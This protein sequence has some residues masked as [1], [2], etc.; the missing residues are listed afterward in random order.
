MVLYGTLNSY[1][2]FKIAGYMANNIVIGLLG[3]T[4]DRGQS[5]ER[6]QRWRPSVA[7]SQHDDFL[8]DRFEL[9]YQKEHQALA[10][11][12][13][14]DI[15]TVSPDIE[16][17]LHP[18]EIDDPWD[19]QSVYTTLL[20]FSRAYP[21]QVDDEDYFIHVTTG[22]QV[23]QI[24]LFLLNE[25]R[26]LPGRLIQES[27]PE[28]GHPGQPGEY[29]T[30]DLDLSKY[31]TIASRFQHEQAASMSALK[32]GIETGNAA[33]N[34]L[35]EQIERVAVWSPSPVLM[36]GPP[37]AGKSRLAERIYQQKRANR[38]V[39]GPFVEVNCATLR[40]GLAM[41]TLFGHVKGAFT[42]AVEDR[43][44]LLNAAQGGVL[45]LDEI[46]EL[47]LDE[48]TM[49]LRAL[50]AN[51]YL[52]VGADVEVAGDFQLI[53]STNRDLNTDVRTGRFRSD[54]LA[55]INLWT[56]YL[57]GLSKRP[58]DIEPNIEFELER[59]AGL[60]GHRVTFNKEAKA[61]FLQFALRPETR[62]PGNFRDLN[63]AITRMATLATG[64]RI[65]IGT[66]DEE[67]GRLEDDW[68]AQ[69]SADRP[70]D[71]D[72]D[73]LERVLGDKRAATI[74]LFDRA[75]LATVIRVCRD[76]RT[77]SDAGRK[78]FAISRQ[79]KTS[80][81]DADRLRKYLARFNLSWQVVTT[82]GD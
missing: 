78:L 65:S 56:F 72:M 67:I 10:D 27:P 24:C 4:L 55:R 51:R 54:L 33:F 26:C 15:R 16:L 48:Q 36:M 53:S 74:D 23:Q 45:F 34:R 73:L 42:G 40:S 79:Y 81:N 13:A 66:V 41:S 8:I 18:I 50:E 63:A 47:G 1:T 75:Q 64:G 38:L 5:D 70:V 22:T 61:Q 82:A 14:A 6:W 69:S 57:P 71:D 20:D 30:I 19:F 68:K 49:L 59:I 77:L 17:Q 7:L 37:G 21:F 11:T 46:G 28:N 58:E 43:A 9:L 32:D 62:W 12:V 80:S 31:D 3:P 2:D 35:V 29:R 52:P 39:S 60:L 44:G 76:A 25:S